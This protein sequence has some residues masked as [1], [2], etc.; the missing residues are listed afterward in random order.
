[1]QHLICKI[2]GTPEELREA[3]RLR[4][5]VFDVEIKEGGVSFQEEG[6]DRDRYDDICDHLLIVDTTSHKVVGTYRLLLDSVAKANDG[7]YCETKFNI[8]N[9]KRLEGRLLEVGRSCVHIDYR[10]R[11]VLNLMWEG[12]A[13]YV[14]RHNVRY[15]FGSANIMTG[16]V[17][18]VS[19]YFKMLRMLGFY[20]ERGIVPVDEAH[21]F[22]LVENIEIQ[23]PRL[24]FKQLPTLLKGYM[25]IGLKVCG[26][27]VKGDF[28]TAL[29][30]ILLDVARTNEH[31]KRKFFGGYLDQISE[32]HESV[33]AYATV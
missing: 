21:A 22:P 26:Y 27:P 6:V 3:L 32:I 25:N 24:L 4:Y 18:R 33:N 20:E 10:D 31:Y 5:Q 29:F 8:E 19:E 7:F 1:M 17:Y 13:Q 15:L 11:L 12:I 2:G 9:F 28:K 16:D 23:N 30:P 14:I